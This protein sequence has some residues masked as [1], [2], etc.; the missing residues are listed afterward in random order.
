[1]NDVTEAV[2]KRKNIIIETTGKKL[3]LKYLNNVKGYN[4][5]FLYILIPEE[6]QREM[7]KTRT[8]TK[9]VSFMTDVIIILLLVYL[10]L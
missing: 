2:K 3:P 8:T 10:I 7:V 4:I 9:L 1:M 6:N 5:I